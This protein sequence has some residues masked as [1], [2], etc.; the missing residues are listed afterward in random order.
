MQNA[1][2]KASDIVAISHPSGPSPEG[3]S[4]QDCQLGERTSVQAKS[5]IFPRYGNGYTKLL[6]PWPRKLDVPVAVLTSYSSAR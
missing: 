5:R 2:L 4:D 6:R 3:I 1:P